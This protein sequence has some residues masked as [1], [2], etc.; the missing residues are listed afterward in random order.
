MNNCVHLWSHALTDKNA[1]KNGPVRQSTKYVDNVQIKALL[2]LHKG[3]SAG[4]FYQ[5]NLAFSSRSRYCRFEK[6]GSVRSGFVLS[7]V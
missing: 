6:E 7:A 3:G 4:S 1:S 2:N 5:I